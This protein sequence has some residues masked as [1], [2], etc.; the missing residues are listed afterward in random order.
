MKSTAAIAFAPNQLLEVLQIDVAGPGP[1]EALVE[2][3]AT[4]V[5]H[6]DAVMLEGQNPKASFPAVLGHEGAGIVRAIGAEVRELD[7]GD[8]VIPLYGSECR[9]CPNCTSGRT[10]LCWGIRET[11]EK[12]LMPDGGRR[13][14]VGDEA[15]YHFMGTSTFS[16]FTVVPEIA[17]AKIRADAPLDKVCLLG[18]GVTTGIGAAINDGGVRPGDTVAVFGLGA[19]GLS[20]IQ[21]AR[22]AGAAKIIGVDINNQKKAIAKT[23]GATDFVNPTKIDGRTVEC[24]LDM[25]SGGVDIALECTGN[26][27]VMRQSLECC[28]VGWGT[29]VLMGVEGR[30]QELSLPP[31]L[32]R[33]G[34]T[35]KG[36][37][38]GG[39]RGRS[40]LPKYVDW[41]MDG[42]I[43]IDALISHVMP[44][45]EINTAFDLMRSGE[46]I[47]TV[48]TF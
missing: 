28:H 42:K 24:I 46:S 15:I 40:G 35:L 9:T 1:M 18:C 8:H 30:D 41:Y 6:T 36:S 33:Y 7:V 48:I 47:R 26:I 16:N 14:S 45:E 38:F 13:F 17:L 21:G 29:C 12:G 23:L 37:Y 25:T 34:R 20:A 27:D 39:V 2:I 43:E 32:V 11:R 22:I 44:I 4:G 10:N 5:C 19:V 3:M 31:V